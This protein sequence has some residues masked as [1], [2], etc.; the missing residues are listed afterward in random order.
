MGGLN[1][2]NLA[3]VFGLLGNIISFIVFLSPMPTFFQ[4]YKKKSTR[5]YQS[6][7]YLVALL[8]AMLLI[9]YAFLKTNATL[10]LTINAF[11]CF[12]EMIYIGLYFFYTP[13]KAKILREFLLV[14]GSFGLM[15]GLT[16]FLTRGPTRLLVVGWICLIFSVC[17]FAA[18]LGIVK[19]VIQTKSVEY[20]PF[21]LSLCHT[22]N[23]VMWF[24]YGYLI[25]D[26]IIFSPNILGFIFGIIQMV[27]YA[28]YGG[29]TKTDLGDEK[30]PSA[31][32]LQSQKTVV[33]VKKV[34]ESAE[35]VI[36]VPKDGG[37]RYLTTA[38][39]NDE[40]PLPPV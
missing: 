19:K 30:P 29:N 33:E 5:G 1:G 15:T 2:L 36:N 12:I 8:S 21:S 39:P 7:P 20:M 17:V 18:P 40:A 4:I 25:R 9:Y 13:K 22:L 11:G 16:Y 26:P 23:S 38:K 35:T 10:L 32:Q 14:I 24:F 6:I 37:A 27:L 31:V 3:F 28:M 34:P